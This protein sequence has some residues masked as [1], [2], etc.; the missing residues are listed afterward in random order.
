M[1]TVGK[2]NFGFKKRRIWGGGP[3]IPGGGRDAGAIEDEKR[4]RKGKWALWLIHYKTKEG[5]N[6]I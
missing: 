1:R 4:L 5:W 6:T 3:V 2:A